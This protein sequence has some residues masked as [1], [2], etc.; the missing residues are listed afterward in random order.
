MFCLFRG[1]AFRKEFSHLNEIRSVIPDTVHVM[2]LTATATLSTRRFIINNLSM[3]VPYII[4]VPPAKSNI[5]YY[6]GDKPKGGVEV[7][8][9]PICEALLKNKKM[10]RVLIFCRSY[11]DVVS[12]HQHFKQLLKEHI[13]EP[14]GQ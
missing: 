6:V 4:Y 11:S 3:D 13:V 9:Q 12:V 5:T 1:T 2:A 10:D 14:P 8:F 7:A